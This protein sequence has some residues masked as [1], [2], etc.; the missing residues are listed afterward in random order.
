[1]VA[2][3]EMSDSRLETI[4]EVD[5]SPQA[6]NELATLAR[7]IAT[8]AS[9]LAN[10]ANLFSEIQPVRNHER[11]LMHDALASLERH[12][13]DM[14]HAFVRAACEKDRTRIAELL[15]GLPSRPPLAVHGVSSSL[16]A[17]HAPPERD[18]PSEP[19]K[20][21]PPLRSIFSKALCP[22][23][24]GIQECGTMNAIWRMFSLSRHA[25]AFR[26]RSDDRLSIINCSHGSERLWSY[27]YIRERSLQD[28]LFNPTAAS[29]IRDK[30]MTG[31]SLES[32]TGAW[33]HQLG[34]YTVRT[35]SKCLFI[36]TIIS[37]AISTQDHDGHPRT[38]MFLI[39]SPYPNFVAKG[40]TTMEPQRNG[41]NNMA[42]HN[43][44]VGVDAN[45]ND[46]RTTVSIATTVSSVDISPEDSV[47]N[48]DASFD[49]T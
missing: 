12:Y 19:Q 16:Q 1:M 48:V 26:C 44:A 42:H 32:E 28:L 47:S 34:E 22:S 27:Q 5:S 24:R 9:E 37:L 49:E 30:A 3:C 45:S 10:L 18:S 11:Q 46:A 20:S 23:R 31:S 41:R 21:V 15:A 7:D 8:M 4:E 2:F 33:I 17:D 40:T 36:A 39:E 25:C 14:H 29:V 6:A 38:L 43:M 35:E 13:F